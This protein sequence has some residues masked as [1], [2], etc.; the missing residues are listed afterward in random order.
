MNSL[1]LS[2]RCKELLSLQLYC[3]LYSSSGNVPV[4]YGLSK[5]NEPGIPLH[6]IVYFLD[7][8]TYNQSNYLVSLISLLVGDS[9]S[10]VRNSVD[11]A[12]IGDA[13]TLPKSVQN[14]G[15]ILCLTSCTFGQFK[16]LLLEVKI[17]TEIAKCGALSL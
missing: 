10:N 2:F 4:L 1:L 14:T 3:H 8:P 6:Y 15:T 11:F 9:P 7:S 5:L 12:R 16:S 17:I 13:A